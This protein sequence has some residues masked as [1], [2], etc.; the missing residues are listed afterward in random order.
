MASRP[1]AAIVVQG[2]LRAQSRDWSGTILQVFLILA[3]LFS[4]AT[5]LVLVVDQVVKAM[6]VFQERGVDFLTSD[7]S[8]NPANA[9]VAQGIFGTVVLAVLVSL[10][11]FPLGIGTAVY[12]E[13]YAPDNRFTRLLVLNIRNL[14]GV[15]SVVFGILGLSVFVAVL[16]AAG[17]GDGR[18]LI[19]GA[20]TLTVLVLPIVII[21]SSEALR[22]VPST[23][24]E[25]GFGIGASRWQ[26]VRKLLLP[27]A[28]PGI[29]TGT[30]LALS[31]ALGETAPL[32]VAGAVLGSYSNT[33]ASPAEILTGPYTA[34]PVIVY[35]WARRPQEE[36]RAL[37]AAAIIVLLVITLI[38][39]TVAIVIR[40]RS[41]RILVSGSDPTGEP[42]TTDLERPAGA[43]TP[44][45]SIRTDAAPAATHDDPAATPAVRF[46][47][48]HFYY[49][50]FRAVKGVS[51]SIRRN[52]ITALIGPSGCGKS[53]LIRSI[54][55]MND[56][57]EGTRVEGIVEFHGENLYA[58]Y[59]DAGRGPPPDRDGLPEG[60]PIPQVDL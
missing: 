42:M 44:T 13:E 39:N 10:L 48:F 60:E 21:T 20:L 40:N 53:T 25:A 8:S 5:L 59:V 55:R 52:R 54:N 56:L 41:E 27:A 33:G 18:N 51:A 24:R 35:D 4:L 16:A 50:K 11:A 34:M 30:V 1:A 31:R 58:D 45:I 2:S 57:I 47:D 23:I 32:I 29:L 14:A 7:L 38:A 46:E 12:L 43:V 49:G 15:P 22:A 28:S 26:V 36:F 3:L 19:S 9:G 37:T 6:P 17:M